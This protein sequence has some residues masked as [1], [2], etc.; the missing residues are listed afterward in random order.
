MITPKNI[1]VATDFGPAA[2][3][4]LSYG[5]MLAAQFRARLHVLH[6]TQ[7]VFMNA[8]AAESFTGMA[9]TLQEEVDEAARKALA[10]RLPHSANGPR[11][12]S[13]VLPGTAPAV[14]IVEYAKD[15]AI[16]L[17]VMGT[18]GR[19]AMAHLMMGSVAERVVRLAPCP[20][21]TIKHPKEGTTGLETMQAVTVV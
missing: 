6:V 18:N 5:R 11:T 20:V 1:L 4:A 13:V 2:D 7:N 10:D 14:A 15:A 12:T 21:L 17:I 8:L 19:G 9:P 16:D 3:E